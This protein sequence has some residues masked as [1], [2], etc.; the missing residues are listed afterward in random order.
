MAL[1]AKSQPSLGD[2]TSD[3]PLAREL[4]A[5]GRT[6]MGH[7]IDIRKTFAFVDADKQHR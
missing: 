2:P 3:R 7:A 6:M 1:T 4:S 5:Y